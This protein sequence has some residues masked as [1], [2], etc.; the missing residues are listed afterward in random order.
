MQLGAAGREVEDLNRMPLSASLEEC[1]Q[2]H[3]DARIGAAVR[4][5]GIVVTRGF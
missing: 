4:K 5:S 1:W 3:G 2:R